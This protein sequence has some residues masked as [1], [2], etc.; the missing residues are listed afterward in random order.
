MAIAIRRRRCDRQA[1]RL[2]TETCATKI[3]ARG[4]A[5]RLGPWAALIPLAVGCAQAA[6]AQDA[7]AIV[8]AAEQ[9]VD[10]TVTEIE[11]PATA[12]A[13]DRVIDFEAR[14]LDYDSESDE[15]GRAT[16]RERVGL[17]V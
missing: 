4:S 16:G 11:V 3:C 9:P 17:Y 13:G 7:A 2:P 1:M 12:Q 8:P 10:T 6:H 5:L 14:E 15:I